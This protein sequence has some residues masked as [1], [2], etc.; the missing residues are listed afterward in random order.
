[1]G[2]CVQAAS[3][4]GRRRFWTPKEAADYLEISVFTLYEYIRPQNPKSSR[5]K[6][7]TSTPPFRRLS[8]NVI[9]FP[10]TEFKAWAERFDHPEQEN[11]NV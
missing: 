11:K 7:R 9:R 4:S 8:R 6:L 10:I 1:M 5:A 3:T 2:A